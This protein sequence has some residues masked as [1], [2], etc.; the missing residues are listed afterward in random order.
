MNRA[1]SKVFI[2]TVVLFVALVVNL[3]WIMVVRAAV[4][5]GPPREQ[6]QHRQGNEDQARRHRR[7]RRLGDRRHGAALRLLLPRLPQRDARSAALRVRLRAVRTRRHRGRA[8]RRRSPGQSSDLGVQN[9]VDKMLGRRPKGANLKLTLV[10]AVQKVAQQA[11]QG[12][13]GRDRAC[14]TP[15]PARS[16]PR[17][18][19]PTYDPANL[20]DQWARL[21]KD[22]TAPLLN[23]PT[24]G[25]Y[26]PGLFVQGRHRL[27]R[28]R[29]RQ[30]HAGHPVR[31]HRNVRGVRRQGH[32]LRRRGVRPQRLHHGHDPV[33]QHHLR[34][35]RQPAR[36]RSGSSP[37]RSGTASTRRRRC[38]CRPARSCP[39]G[40]TAARASCCRRRRS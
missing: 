40:G 18:R 4:V 1:M 10:P 5:P 35:G 6:A 21:S 30:G 25:L 20:E 16:S 34:Q 14:S 36:P 26:V 24:Q 9:W 33:D 22:A 32:Q 29:H 2:I 15:R 28:A 37:A 31:G 17:R 3:T 23:R 8:Q 38:R 27:G 12:Q 39:A 19:R 13:E 11:L 7:L